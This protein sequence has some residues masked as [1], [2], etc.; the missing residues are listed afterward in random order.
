MPTDLDLREL[1]CP[2]ALASIGPAGTSFAAGRRRLS[3]RRPPL[4]AQRGLL[5]ICRAPRL[6]RRGRNPSD[7]L[8]RLRPQRPLLRQAVRGGDQP[9]G[10]DGGRRQRLDAIRRVDRLQIRLRAARLRLPVAVDAAATRRRG[11][12]LHRERRSGPMSRRVPTPITCG[13]LPTS[14]SAPRPG[15][16]TSL[17]SVLHGVGKRLKRRGLVV[18]FSDCF[19]DVD[20]LIK[21]LR[22]LRLRGHDVLVFHVLAPEERTF[23]FNRWSR[24]ECLETAGLHLDLDPSSIRQRY[25]ERLQTFLDDLQRECLRSPLRPGSAFDGTAPGRGSWPTI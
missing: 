19:D 16:A 18:V 3:F 11:I 15:G 10:P 7:R 6:R 8:A 2:A 22:L 9:S 24:F 12:D 14:W 4:H 17:A 13:P 21:S 5:R 25:L 1:M 23:S 20:A